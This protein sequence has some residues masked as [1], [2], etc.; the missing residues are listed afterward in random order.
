MDKL[1][2]GSGFPSGNA[3]QCIETLLGFNMLLADTNLP[4]V[5]RGSIR[6]VIERNTLELLGIDNKSPEI[7]EE[8]G[9]KSKDRKK[10]GDLKEKEKPNSD[11]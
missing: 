7:Q 6:N 3:G 2:F 10:T 5:P 8:K 9:K 4:T 11:C 1:L